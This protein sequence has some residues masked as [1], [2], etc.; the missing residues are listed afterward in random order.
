MGNTLDIGTVGRKNETAMDI[1]EL[2][3]QMSV[4]DHSMTGLAKSI[5][6]MQAACKM[7]LLHLE[8]KEE[9]NTDDCLEGENEDRKQSGPDLALELLRSIDESVTDHKFIA[10]DV[11]G[12][13]LHFIA[14]NLQKYGISSMKSDKELTLDKY[15]AAKCPFDM[16][17]TVLFYDEKIKSL[18]SEVGKLKEIKRNLR[19]RIDTMQRREDDLIEENTCLHDQVDKLEIKLNISRQD[20]QTIPSTADGNDKQFTETNNIPLKVETVEKQKDKFDDMLEEHLSEKVKELVDL[21]KERE[22]ERQKFEEEIAQY[23]NENTVLEDANRTLVEELERKKPAKVIQVQVQMY[24]NLCSM[25]IETSLADF[26]KYKAKTKSLDLK[27]ITYYKRLA[28]ERDK[29]V[30][31]LC[32]SSSVS[33]SS[34]KTGNAIGGIEAT[35]NAAVVVLHKDSK[36]SIQYK[37]AA[38]LKKYHPYSSLGEIVDV[39]CDSNSVFLCDDNDYA[40]DDI[41]NYIYKRR[42]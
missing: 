39:A 9:I 11:I 3:K 32:D 30:I 28:V 14:N 21:K 16:T 36:K 10:M 13:L 35:Q 5:D 34:K 2:Q 19:S 23:K 24:R 33:T 1:A 8:K 22:I 31:I 17:G 18:R 6:S 42:S 15:V 20:K 37:Q 27:I 40:V 26:L 38:M 29:P 7:L 41:I 12:R 25:S 4:V